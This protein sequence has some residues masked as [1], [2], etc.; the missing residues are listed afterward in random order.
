M[1]SLWFLINLVRWTPDT[2]RQRSKMH[3]RAL[4]LTRGCVSW[5]TLMAHVPTSFRLLPHGSLLTFP[6][7]DGVGEQKGREE[8]LATGRPHAAPQCRESNQRELFSRAIPGHSTCNF[9]TRCSFSLT[10]LFL[11]LDTQPADLIYWCISSAW[12][13]AWRKVAQCDHVYWIN[14]WNG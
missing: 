14:E 3:T 6:C 9:Q 5:S 10:H 8:L 11:C 12:P 7:N 13:G 1:P 4:S 2:P